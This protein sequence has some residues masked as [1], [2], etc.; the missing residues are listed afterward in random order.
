MR[1]IHINEIVEKVRALS[2]DININLGKDVADA[3]E[4]AYDIEESPAGKQT[5]SYLL[6]NIRIARE[7]SVP[8]CQD[9]GLAV[10]FVEIGQD[11]HIVGG[12]L[13]DAINEGVR[14]GYREGYLRK[15][16]L[17]DP[18][19]RR[20]T[21]DNTPAV[22]HFD[23]ISGNKL[24]IKMAAKGGGSENSSAMKMMKP[25]D[26]V[27]GIKEFVL[28]TVTSAWANPCPPIIVGIG[29]GGDFEMAPTLAKKALF[30]HL[31]D[32]NPAPHIA[33][34]EMNI[35]KEVNGLRI[36]PEGFGGTVTAL[37]VHIETAP[38]HIA[39]LPVAVNIDCHVS[40]HREVML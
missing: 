4:K 18:I 8:I 20:N 6:E 19:L 21:G 5:L 12:D 17:D 1:Q 11:V 9:T 33:D 30:R 34:L 38:C 24:K 16:V 40:R 32:H 37:A 29:I 22:I 35:L 36:G 26:G 14:Q 7:E 15:S 28:D 31:G 27:E 3:L 23:I 10:L 25:S 2:I 13:K 39:S